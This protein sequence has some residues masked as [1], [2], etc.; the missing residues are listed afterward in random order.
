MNSFNTHDETLKVVKKYTGI[1]ANI[2][3]FNQSRFPR[4]HKETLLPLTEDPYADKE[5]WFVIH[6]M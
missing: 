1:K 4:I 3:N 6:F 5:N 2:L